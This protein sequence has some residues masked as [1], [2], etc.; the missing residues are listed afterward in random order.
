M[1]KTYKVHRDYDVDWMTLEDPCR[2]ERPSSGMT[3]FSQESPSVKA[4]AALASY[5]NTM[6]GTVMSHENIEWGKLKKS[7]CEA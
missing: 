2:C 4:M 7:E 1:G 5:N 3:I 6:N